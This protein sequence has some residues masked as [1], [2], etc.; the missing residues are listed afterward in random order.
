MVRAMVRKTFLSVLFFLCTLVTSVLFGQ[1]PNT[2]VY[3][4]AIATDTTLPPLV[5]RWEA[6]LVGSISTSATSITITNATGLIKPIVL[7][8]DE[9][10][11]K[12]EDVLVTNIVGNVL[13][14]VRGYDTSSP[15]THNNGASVH[16]YIVAYHFNQMFAE[17][18]ALQTTLG[19]N[20]SNVSGS[21]I[22]CATP[23]ELTIASGGVTISTDACY[24]IDTE[25][26]TPTDD[27]ELVTCA[28]GRQFILRPAEDSRTVVV[29][30]NSAI[31]IRA[32]FSLNSQYDTF[33]GLCIASNTVVAISRKSNEF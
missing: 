3:P 14:V 27:L 32:D 24:T 16:G 5:N 4:G 8:L 25:G 12:A 22:N 30:D 19:I 1:N 17:L 21:G 10:T 11:T 18:K 23:T 2:A 7:T 31:R 9:G 29:K 13:T 20:L 6:R 15:F 33:H 26:D 28:T